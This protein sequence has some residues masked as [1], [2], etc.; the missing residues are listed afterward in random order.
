LEQQA[1]EVRATDKR[2]AL[3]L[4]REATRLRRVAR[5]VDIQHKRAQRARMRRE[6]DR[7]DP[8][9][10]QSRAAWLTFLANQQ[11]QQASGFD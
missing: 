3:Q 7:V 9:I 4:M 11:G 2:F 1:A 5:G 10:D 6:S 8:A